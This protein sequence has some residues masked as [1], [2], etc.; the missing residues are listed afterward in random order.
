V[1]YLSLL[2]ISKEPKIYDEKNSE[3]ILFSEEIFDS[4]R[5]G[6]VPNLI[7]NIESISDEKIK[8]LMKH[9]LEYIKLDSPQIKSLTEI[10]KNV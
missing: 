1:I 10:N 5:D 7:E 6:K 3:N 2:I 9:L 8:I 4:L